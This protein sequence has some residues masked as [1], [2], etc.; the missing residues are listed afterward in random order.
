VTE[1]V[2]AISE[3]PG[4]VRLALQVKPRSAKTAVLGEQDGA[5]VVSLRSAP[6]DGAANEE[7]VSV[8]AAAFGVRRAAVAIAVGATGRRKLVDLAGLTVAE[9]R[10]RVAALK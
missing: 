2:D 4:G 3:R 5:L 1:P 9:A 7:L 6:V 8:L 10:A